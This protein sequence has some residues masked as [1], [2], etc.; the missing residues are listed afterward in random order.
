MGCFDTVRL[1]CPVCDQSEI[2][3]QSKAGDCELV[4]YTE[5]AVPVEIAAAIQGKRARC[6]ECGVSVVIESEA[7]EMVRVEAREAKRCTGCNGAG[8][9]T[10]VDGNPRSG[11]HLE[12]CDLCKGTGK[13]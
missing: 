11:S 9:Y 12:F 1:R 5:R 13:R 8:E 6:S 3:I 7:P 2:E 10:V 4:E